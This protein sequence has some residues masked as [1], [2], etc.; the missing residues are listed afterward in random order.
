M[1]VLLEK[2]KIRKTRYPLSWVIRHVISVMFLFAIAQVEVYAGGDE[3]DNAGRE[4][5]FRLF[6]PNAPD[7]RRV[8]VIGNFNSWRRGS[9][10]LQGPDKNSKWETRVIL[11]SGVTRIEYI[12]LVDGK[13]Y[14]DSRQGVIS[15]DF[16]SKNNI[17]TLP[18]ASSDGGG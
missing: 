6:L 8:E 2:R 15:D 9:T 4:A 16:G 3:A 13:R 1:L 14:I 18:E 12:Y 5:V 17:L 7:V 10:P 11:K